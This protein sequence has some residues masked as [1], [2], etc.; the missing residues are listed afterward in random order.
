[1][2]T[3]DFR[4]DGRALVGTCRA[5]GSSAVLKTG[6]RNVPGDHG[7][8]RGGGGSALCPPAQAGI[9]VVSTKVFRDSATCAIVSG[10]TLGPSFVY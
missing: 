3:E 2:E 6:S 10:T 1:M 5:E 4:E 8:E 7:R 9:Q